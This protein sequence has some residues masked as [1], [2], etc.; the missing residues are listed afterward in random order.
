MG[1]KYCFD[2][3]ISVLVTDDADDETPDV[4]YSSSDD[5]TF[6]Y[7]YSIDLPTGQYDVTA[8]CEGLDPEEVQNFIADDSVFALNFDF[9][10]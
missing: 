8:S 4:Y 10:D 9:N 6:Q 7:I 3:H 1:I 2:N 5:G